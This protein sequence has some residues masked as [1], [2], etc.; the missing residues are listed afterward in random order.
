MDEQLLRSKNL[1]FATA[2][3]AVPTPAPFGKAGNFVDPETGFG[4][5]LPPKLY[6]NNT[7][8]VRYIEVQCSNEL[9]AIYYIQLI[10]FDNTRLEIGKAQPD[11]KIVSYNFNESERLVTMY[12][13]S[14]APSEGKPDS[15]MFGQIEFTTDK[16]V[17]NQENPENHFIAGPDSSNYVEI[18]PTVANQALAGFKVQ[19]VSLSSDPTNDCGFIALEVWINKPSSNTVLSNLSN[20][21]ENDISANSQNLRY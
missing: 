13:R 16:T 3:T 12:L 14:V 9:K 1:F 19:C 21:P 10:F 17:T 4:S 11:S 7:S 5:I 6:T 15:G 8:N 20:N 18:S 2:P